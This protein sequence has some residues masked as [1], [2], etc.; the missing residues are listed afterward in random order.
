M[1]KIVKRCFKNEKKFSKT[2]KNK[3]KKRKVITWDVN[4]DS[5]VFSKLLETKTNSKY[6]IEIKFDKTIRQLVVIIPK[7]SGYVKTFKVEDK[8]NKLMSFH[9]DG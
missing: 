1:C 3:K 6:V 7:M 2:K 8:V 4:V 9:I 5:I